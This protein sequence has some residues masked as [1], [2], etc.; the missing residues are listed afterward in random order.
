MVSDRISRLRN[1]I[2]NENYTGAERT[3]TSFTPAEQQHIMRLYP[4]L[5]E[6]FMNMHHRLRAGNR[7]HMNNRY[8]AA[9]HNVMNR[10]NKNNHEDP[11][12]LEPFRRGEVVVR[13]KTSGRRTAEYFSIESFIDLFGPLES[14]LHKGPDQSISTAIWRSY[15]QR[16]ILRKDV[17]FVEMV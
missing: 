12:T 14:W 16:P 3:L 7:S 6:I 13:L 5:Y 4:Q 1:Q 17:S 15:G 2:R 10:V 9:F 8:I 11:I